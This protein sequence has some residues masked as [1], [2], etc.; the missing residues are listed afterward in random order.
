MYRRY[1]LRLMLLFV[2]A[3]VWAQADDRDRQF[4]NGKFRDPETKFRHE[5]SSLLVQAVQGRKPGRAIDLRGGMRCTWRRT[6]GR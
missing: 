5:A 3:L 4:W 1:V 2:P 6:D